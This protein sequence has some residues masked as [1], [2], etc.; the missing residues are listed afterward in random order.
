MADEH[1]G[2]AAVHR[3]VTIIYVYIYMGMGWIKTAM[4]FFKIIGGNKELHSTHIEYIIG[5]H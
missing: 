1:T 5:I 4:F 3:L 2:D